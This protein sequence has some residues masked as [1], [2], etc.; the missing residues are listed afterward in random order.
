MATIDEVRT[1]NLNDLIGKHGGVM[2]FSAL[3][4][5]D[6]TQIAQ[7]SKNYPN[8]QG[9]PRYISGKMC[10]HI[11]NCLGLLNEWMDQD[12]SSG[13]IALAGTQQTVPLISWVAAGN[14]TP[15]SDPPDDFQQVLC[16]F[17]HGKGTFALEVRGIS[18]EN[19]DHKPSFSDGDWIYVDPTRDANHRDFVV[20]RLDD[21][22]EATFKQLLIEGGQKMLFA[23]NKDWK[24]RI[25]PINGNA[26]I[27]GVVIGKVERW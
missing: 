26:T 4:G 21:E 16:P 22:G 11:E 15:M 9:K 13:N 8:A 27:V 7:W 17:P 23:L 14:W 24:P 5:K 25:L 19:T 1:K 3:V 20:V 2:K 12:H 10:R 6:R 18:M